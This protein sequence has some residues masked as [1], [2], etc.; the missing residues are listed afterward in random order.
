MNFKILADFVNHYNK[1]KKMT[2]TNLANIYFL[3]SMSQNNNNTDYKGKY[4]V[5]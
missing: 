5:A 4:R 3:K 2:I 1:G